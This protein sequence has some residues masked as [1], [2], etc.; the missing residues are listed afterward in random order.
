MSKLTEQKKA[1]LQLIAELTL[2]ATL[3]A[4]QKIS[5]LATRTK[6]AS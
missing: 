2:D 4:E 5:K 3:A 6:T 1:E